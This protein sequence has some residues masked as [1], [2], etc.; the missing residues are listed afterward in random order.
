MKETSGKL[1]INSIPDVKRSSGSNSFRED[2]GA[3]NGEKNREGNTTSLEGF[4]SFHS[5][6]AYVTPKIVQDGWVDEKGC[7]LDLASFRALFS[8]RH[9]HSVLEALITRRDVA[10]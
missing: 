3:G 2:E 5:S 7:E 4:R 8:F 10:R 6:V 9:A 1:R